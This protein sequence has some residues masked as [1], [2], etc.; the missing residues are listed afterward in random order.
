M[1]FLEIDSPLI[2]ESGSSVNINEEIS[3][4]YSQNVEDKIL[5]IK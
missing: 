3:S 1:V 2:I 4:Q 5:S